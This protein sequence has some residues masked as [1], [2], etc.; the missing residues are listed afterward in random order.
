EALHLVPAGFAEFWRAPRQLSPESGPG[1]M[2]RG[3]NAQ[4]FS[5]IAELP[6]YAA[7]DPATRAIVDLGGAHSSMI[8]PLRKDGVTLGAITI[9][10]QE[11]RPFSDKQIALL[12]NFAAQAVIAME[13]ARLLTEQREAL[14]Q[15][16]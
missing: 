10:R 14:E 5:D 13:N 8:A 16:T 7:D 6:L 3:E 12:G 9:Y 2:M 15:Q 11:V 1:R 4:A